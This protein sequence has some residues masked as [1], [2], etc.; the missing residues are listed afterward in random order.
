MIGP[1]AAKEIEQKP[2]QAAESGVPGEEITR[3]QGAEQRSVETLEQQGIRP[4]WQWEEIRRHNDVARARKAAAELQRN[5]LQAMYE[6][7]VAMRVRKEREKVCY[8]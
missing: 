4:E 5:E 2:P 1:G 8:T 7:A 6:S 3:Q